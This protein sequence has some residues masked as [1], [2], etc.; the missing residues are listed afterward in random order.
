LTAGAS[1][2][3][4]TA[5]GAT[6]M[7][8]WRMLTRVLGLASTLVVARVLVPADF[9]L[10]AMA[11]TLAAAVEAMSQIGVQSALV[12]HPDSERLLNTGFTLQLGCG[13]ATGLVVALGAPAAAWWFTEPRLTPLLFILAGCA[14]VAGL[15]NIGIVAFR[16]DMRFEKQ[17]AL[18]SG[19]RLLQVAVT[20]PLALLLQNYWALLS[21][22]VVSRLV[23]TAMTY[24]VHPYRP[25]LTLAGWRELGQFS[26]WT[27]VSALAGLVWDRCDPFVLGPGLGAGRLGMYVQSL[28][29]ATLP[30]TELVVPAADALLA[31]FS[32]A[33]RQGS[34][35]VP[36]APMVALA[37]V[38]GILPLVIT[39]SCAA[40]DVVAVL[41]G[42]N[43]AEAQGL[44]AILAWQGVFAPFAFVV[45]VTLVANGLVQR[46]FVANSIASAIKFTALMATVALTRRLDSVAWVIVGCVA[47]EAV[48]FLLLLPRGGAGRLRDLLA[49][50]GRAMLAAG[51][52]VLALWVLGLAW[53]GVTR[54]SPPAFAN[55]LLIGVVTLVAYTVALF[56]AWLAVGQP[57]GP[58]RRLLNLLGTGPGLLRARLSRWR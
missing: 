33:Q 56:G 30:T 47:C 36:S 28:E 55:G 4:Q 40:G 34:S 23:R 22:I 41:L 17:F 27:W 43:W 8:A 35:S 44:V 31:G 42:P 57:E 20:V 32:S 18:L 46:N 50:F 45:G 39:I 5:V 2:L 52:A 10:L 37:L 21:G 12:R 58:E 14:V 26:F 19:P 53:Q 1:L 16:R 6:W 48:V 49:G 3:R 38:M 29:L 7:V 51:A 15:E 11:T 9:G 24:V 13:I 54:A 25:R